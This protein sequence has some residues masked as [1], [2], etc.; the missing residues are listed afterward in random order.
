[1]KFLTRKTK[2]KPLAKLL[3]LTTLLLVCFVPE[4]FATPNDLD[5]IISST[6][7][8]PGDQVVVTIDLQ[9]VAQSLAATETNGIYGSNFTITYDSTALQVGTISAGN[10]F[11]VPSDF[12]S[13]KST[14]GK[15]TLLSLDNS[16]GD[17]LITTD[18]TY[19]TIPFTIKAGTPA[20]EYLLDFEGAVTINGLDELYAQKALSITKTLGSITVTS[21]TPTAPDAPTNPVQDDV[22][23]TFGW[24][25]VAGFTQASDYEYSVDGGTSWVTAT[26]NPQPLPDAAYAIGAVQARVKANISTSQPEGEALSSTIAFTINPVVPAA[27]SV[28]NDDEA[29]TVDG[30]AAGMEYNLDSAGYVAYSATTFAGLD[31]AGNHTLLVRVA[32]EGINP[33]GPSTTLTFT[34]N[35]VTPAAPSVTRDDTANTV[36]GMSAVM[37]YNLD[38]AGYVVYNADTFAGLDLTGNHTL[39][40]R[41]AAEGI[42]PAGPDTTLTFTTNPVTPAAPSVSN[43]DE[44]NTVDGMAAGMEYNLDSAGYVAYSAT[45]FAGLDFAGNHTL[46]VRVAAE[47]I[48]PEGPSTTLTFTTNPVTP[49]APSVSNDD[50][51]NTVDGM[52]AGMEY[53]LDSAGYVAYSA[54][55]FAGLDF[56]GN[57]TL[58]VR[59]AA[60][61][62]NPEGPSTTLTF[63]TNPVTPAAPSVSNDDE[64]NTVDGM[65]AGMEYNLDSAGYVAYNATT[66]A[67]LDFAGNHTLVVRVA[68]SGINPASNEVTLTFTVNPVVTS[69]TYKSVDIDSTN[70]IVTLTF[71]DNIANNTADLVALKNAIT[72]AADGTTFNPLSESDTVTISGKTLV[73]TFDT[74]L[75]E[76]SN[77]IKLEANTL[78]DLGDEVLE[79]EVT[80]GPISTFDECFIATAAFGSKN[81]SDVV[82]LR[83][84]RDQFLLTNPIGQ[85]FVETY[86]NNSPPIA[87]F[88]AG[89]TILKFVT[90]VLLLP[91]VAIVYLLFHPVLLVGVLAALAFLLVQRRRRKV[92]LGSR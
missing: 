75:L 57:H 84:F 8:L 66:F 25:N 44:A 38:N 62:I 87:Q 2:L 31:F 63:T 1:M 67:G 47:G 39:L 21:L 23:N 81:Q 88:I 80:A 86:Y 12:L 70:K 76:S 35:P 73:I 60:E 92:V 40:V 24:T 90:R 54:T 14:L 74:A 61:G 48:N 41:V 27:P 28:S 69:L 32:A 16:G 36:A 20:A 4:V 13:N 58:L 19:A 89:N 17:N 83:Q 52:A 42:N 6:S 18:G 26:A 9:N 15:I 91:F 45:T 59:V 65:A 46:L 34:T 11:T 77:T 56:A 85:L 68:A 33:E 22:N 78:K 72:F 7:G 30:M 50:E 82:L 53:N 71:N 49:A 10:L 29:N 64:A 3:I 51:A 5:V 55:T 37:E 79:T 43:D